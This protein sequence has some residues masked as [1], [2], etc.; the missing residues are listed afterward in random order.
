MRFFFFS[1]QETFWV[2]SNDLTI[3]LFR[4]RVQPLLTHDFRSIEI[5]SNCEKFKYLTKNDGISMDNVAFRLNEKANIMTHDFHR[6]PF[7]LFSVNFVNGFFPQIYWISVKISSKFSRCNFFFFFIL[8][9]RSFRT[10]KDIK[11]CV[12]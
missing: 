1:F 6:S 7:E 8:I 11:C 3:N 4:H 12:R 10:L 9:I 5:I 2:N